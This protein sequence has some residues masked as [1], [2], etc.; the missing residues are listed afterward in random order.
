[1]KKIKTFLTRN[2]PN[3][4]KDYH[5]NNY[6]M[7]NDKG[8]IPEKLEFAS[9]NLNEFFGGGLEPGV[10]TNIYGEAGAAKTSFAL[11]AAKSCINKGKKVIFIDTEGG[12]SVE[13]FCQMNK[14]EKL[15]MLFLI[16]PK[17]F[18]DQN[19]AIGSLEKKIEEEKEKIG[20]I[21]IDSLVSL[22]RLELHNGD[23]QPTNR[24]LSAQMATLIRIAKDRNIPVIA[25]NQ[26]YSDFETGNIELV[27]GDI[28]KYASKCLVLLEKIEWG[29]RKMTMIKHRSLPEGK[30]TT[31]EI[32]NEG[33]VDCK[34]KLG[35]F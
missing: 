5:N 25:T 16:E 34:K 35:I 29:K 27:G 9:E 18:R 26:V 10:I 6:I 2:N 20:L 8:T 11:E 15:E 7:D 17:T 33:L 22:Y 1:M 31:F 3:E 13:R 23:V 4:I 19:T 21:I 24:M 30:K 32:K 28:P 12:F 14:K